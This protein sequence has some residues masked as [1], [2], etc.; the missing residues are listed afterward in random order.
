MNSVSKFKYSPEEEVTFAT[1]FHFYVEVFPKNCT[2]WSDEQKI[3]LLL[4]KFTHSEYKKY[5]NYILQTN[6]AET[7]FEEIVLILKKYLG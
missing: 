5:A 7:S 2:T 1:Y 6:P 4:G 3:R